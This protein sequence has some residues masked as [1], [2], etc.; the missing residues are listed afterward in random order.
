MTKYNIV[1]ISS[2]NKIVTSLEE[3]IKMYKLGFRVHDSN[4]AKK[5]YWNYML[6]SFSKL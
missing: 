5:F 6:K 2:D 4:P 1:S 3:S